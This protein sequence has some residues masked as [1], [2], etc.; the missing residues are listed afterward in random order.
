M[1]DWQKWHWNGLGWAMFG[2][3]GNILDRAMNPEAE[4]GGEEG[5]DEEAF[6][7]R[8]RAGDFGLSLMALLPPVIRADQQ[9][10][11]PELDFV[12]YFFVKT[13]GTEQAQDLMALL[14]NILDLDYSLQGVCRQIHKLM[15]YPSRLGMIHLL[16]G[17][18][19]AD[20]DIDPHE[21]RVIQE[22]SGNIGISRQ[23]LESIQAMFI[24]NGS[25]PYKILGV[26]SDVGREA[27]EQAYKEACDK[28]HP[29]KVSHLGEEFQK[30]AG[31]KFEAIKKAYRQIKHERGWD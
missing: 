2:P 7:P 22:I 30:L 31:E 18:A 23:D 16:F 6:Y 19:R 15:D 29:D 4:T 11:Q 10:S 17:L 21:V 1:T 28:H 5:F 9:I 25:T 26:D 3:L 14:K 27:L 20:A 8:T 24:R 13:F 12:H